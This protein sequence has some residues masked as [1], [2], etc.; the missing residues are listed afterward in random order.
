VT[1]GEDEPLTRLDDA[2]SGPQMLRGE[3]IQGESKN[4]SQKGRE[5]KEGCNSCSTYTGKTTKRART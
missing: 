2:R 4:V 3:N 1:K 5:R